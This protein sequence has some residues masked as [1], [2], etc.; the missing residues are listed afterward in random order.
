MTLIVEQ[1]H[2]G[3]Q[4]Q[5]GPRHAVAHLGMTT[6]GAADLTM[7]R[8]CNSLAGNNPDRLLPLLEIP[9]GGLVLRASRPV[10]VAFCG[11]G[12]KP[13]VNGL[14]VEAWRSLYLNSGDV[15]SSGYSRRAAR[16]YLA[17]QG[18]FI[19]NE[20]LGSCSTVRREGVGGFDGKA[21]VLAPALPLPHQ[22]SEQ[23]QQVSLPYAEQP[24]LPAVLTLALVV[25]AQWRLLHEA[26]TMRGQDLAADIKNRLF[27]VS[28]QSDRMGIR[29]SAE[30]LVCVR[31]A[32]YSEG[33]CSGAVQLPPDGRP[34]IMHVDHQTIGGYPKLGTITPAAVDLLAQAL[35]GQWIKFSLTNAAAALQQERIRQQS[36][37]QTLNGIWRQW[38]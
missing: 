37:Q 18:G 5:D 24:G 32:M 15:F 14:P 9:L 17:V 23:Y 27:R 33:L 22:P 20:Q 30:P 10:V 21:A 6:G 11:I 3:V 36:I 38:Q 35:P 12:F 34:I 1:T 29:L 19:A 28:T 8:I 13:S 31:T 7:A 4:L 26:A 16:A 25:G 2:A